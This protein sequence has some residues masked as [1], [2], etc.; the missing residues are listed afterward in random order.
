[1]LRRR[2]IVLEDCRIGVLEV[3]ACNGMCVSSKSVSLLLS[4]LLPL[5]PSV[6]WLLMSK[7]SGDMRSEMM[8]FERCGMSSSSPL[9]MDA[10]LADASALPTDIIC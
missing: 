10:S 6:S 3:K 4:M 1:M 7:Y 5:S 9:P 2:E 8:I